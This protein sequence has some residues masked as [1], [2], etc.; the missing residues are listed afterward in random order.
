MNMRLKKWIL[1][2]LPYVGIALFATKLGQAIRIAP[3]AD[4][5]G[6]VL[7]MMDGLHAAFSTAVPSFHPLDLCVG[8]LVAAAI[9]LTVYVKGKNA[10]KF[11]KNTEYGSARW[12]NEKDIKPF[13]DPKFENNMLLTATE[14]LTMNTRPTN[15]ANARNL[16]FCGIGSSGSGKTRFWLTPQL[17]QAHSSYVV[18]D[19]KGG[20]LG[21]VGS[22][23]QKRGYKIKVFNS[24][25]FS[26]SMHYNPLAYIKT[27]ADIL[28]FVNALISNTKGEGKEGDPFWTK[29]ETLLYCALLGYII[30]EGAEE[31]R[32]MNTLVDM[33]SGM[34]VKEDDE[35]FL[36][37]VDYMFKGLEQRKPNCFAVKQ[38]KKY[39][40][41]SG[42]ICSK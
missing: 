33:I 21:Q 34:E 4:F 14:R 12:G 2:N 37:A 17:L 32:N 18:V 25:D 3:G 6:K 27:E 11:R 40:L 39:K 22:F 1:P 26:K 35:D 8:V 19:P 5:S 10:K 13:V 20:V 36:N 16:N 29:A 31:D 15:P 7:H 38:Y 41:S 30:F 9:R 42:D 24:I 28:K 23:L